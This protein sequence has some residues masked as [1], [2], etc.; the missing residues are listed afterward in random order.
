MHKQTTLTTQ[1]RHVVPRVAEADSR[2][3]RIYRGLLASLG[4]V[5]LLCASP[6]IWAQVAPPL[7][8]AQQFGALGNSGVVGSAGAGTVVNGDV[9]SSPSAPAVTNFTDTAGPS[10]VLAPFV[11]HSAA[12]AV[13]L[14]AHNDA[15]AAFGAL[16]QACNATYASG[17]DLGGMNLVPG[18]YC[19]LGS[20]AITGVLTLTGT[21]SDVWI[22]RTALS[23]LDA[24]I[25]SSV[26]MA[27]G[28]SACN[29][30]WQVGSSANLLGTSF[31]GTVIADASI[32]LDSGNVTGRLLAGTGPAGAVTMSVGGNTIGGCSLN[33]PLVLGA[34]APT[35]SKSFSPTT[36]AAGGTSTLTITLSNTSTDTVDTIASLTDN[37]LPSGLT[38]VGA[39]ATTCGGPAPVTTAT[40]VTLGAGG[41]IPVANLITNT[42][43]TCTVT[44]SVTSATAGAHVNTV[45][46]NDLVTNN[47]NN[48]AP[49]SA[50][51]TVFT[52]LG[53]MDVPTLSEWAMI[54]L[55]SLL[56]IV[57]FAA[58]R[59]QSR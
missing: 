22:F 11:I 17:T 23:T 15:I 4:F 39:A 26:L 56:A 53:A 59:R 30:Y 43:G 37:L 40:S 55:A 12:N 36:I 51:L 45:L 7:G 34:I 33:A 44:V 9:G 42:P 57:G 46:A 35:V 8:V 5:A 6:T 50:T 29:V 2:F 54:L 18:V 58:M 49:A 47:G 48:A 38:T 32:T 31:S 25:G 1:T 20:F 13:T 27:G 21:A 10:S 24:A 41:T 28:S 52:P 14:Q 3:N 19:S 16:G